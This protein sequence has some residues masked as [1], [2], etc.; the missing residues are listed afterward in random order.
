MENGASSYHRFLQGDK[1]ALGEL[2]ERYS[3]A[4][5]RYA[6]CFVHSS[7]VAEDVAEDAFAALIVK[8]KNLLNDSDFAAYLFRTA[9]NT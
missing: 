4:V 3:D 6:Y 8:R 5:V 1:S 2:V 7:V 9:R